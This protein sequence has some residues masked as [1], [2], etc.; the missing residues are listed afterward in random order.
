MWLQVVVDAP[1]IITQEFLDEHGIDF[2]AHDPEPYPFG[3]IADV[4]AFVKEQ[5]RFRATQRTEGI[6]TSDIITRILFNYDELIRRNLV[7]GYTPQQLNLSFLQAK[8]IRIEDR[9]RDLRKAFLRQVSRV[10]ER[11]QSLMRSLEQS[12][13][14]CVFVMVCDDVMM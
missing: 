14:V 10:E 3:N 1:W 11:T 2:V 7:R 8:R 6:S 4:Y 13:E 12:A 9:V 5:G